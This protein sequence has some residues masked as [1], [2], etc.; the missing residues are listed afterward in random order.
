MDMGWRLIST[1][2]LLAAGVLTNKIVDGGWKA[3]TGHEPPTDEDDPDVGAWQ[4]I[5]FAAVSGALLGLARHYALKGA[6]KVY[7]AEKRVDKH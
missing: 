7:P 1:G 3:I 5:V 6:A 4:V 2:A